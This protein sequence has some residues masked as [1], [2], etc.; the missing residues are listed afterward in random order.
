MTNAFFKVRR[1]HDLGFISRTLPIFSFH[2]DKNHFRLCVRRTPFEI[3][4]FVVHSL[5]NPLVPLVIHIQ[6]SFSS[7]D[8][9]Y[10]SPNSHVTDFVPP[11]DRLLQ[12]L[13]PCALINILIFKGDRPT[14][15]LLAFFR[16]IL[17]DPSTHPHPDISNNL[18][19]PADRFI[20]AARS[21]WI[22]SRASSVPATISAAA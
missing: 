21:P 10:P 3:F 20:Q 2:L 19:P 18:P 12:L 7:H 5:W 8:S 6:A 4:R 17:Q 16:F 22:S 13:P 11:P 9:V 14:T 15:A 1:S